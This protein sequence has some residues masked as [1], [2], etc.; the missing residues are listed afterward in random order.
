MN[1]VYFDYTISVIAKAIQMLSRIGEEM[2]VIPQE[3]CLS[4]RS[5]NGANSAFSDVSFYDNYFS[6]YAYENSENSETLK[7]KIPI[8]VSWNFSKI[9]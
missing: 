4:L 6:Y 2:F 5:V 7:C 8:R 1:Y 9:L 3:D